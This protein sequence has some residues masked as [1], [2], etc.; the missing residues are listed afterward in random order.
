[1]L[2]IAQH[3]IADFIPADC[4]LQNPDLWIKLR[5]NPMISDCMC[6]NEETGGVDKY[7]HACQDPCDGKALYLVLH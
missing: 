5:Y 1:M 4:Q 3:P 7:P 6:L 2:L